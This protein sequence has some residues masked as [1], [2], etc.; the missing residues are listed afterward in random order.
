MSMTPNTI[1]VVPPITR[2]RVWICKCD[3]RAT[4]LKKVFREHFLLNFTK[5][6]TSYWFKKTSLWVND[7]WMLMFGWIIPLKI[8]IMIFSLHKLPGSKL[9][10]SKKR[11]WDFSCLKH[12]SQTGN[13]TVAFVF[14]PSFLQTKASHVVNPVSLS[15]HF[16]A[17]LQKKRP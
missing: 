1:W 4:A 7:D 9:S 6:T 12:L 2:W 10:A 11:K 5:E 16:S 14:Y 15:L 8:N 17:N 3:L 13:K